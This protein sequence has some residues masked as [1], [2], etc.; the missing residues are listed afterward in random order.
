MNELKITRKEIDGAFAGANITTGSTGPKGGN[1]SYGGCSFLT[2]DFYDLGVPEISVWVDKQ[3]A[4]HAE[5]HIQGAIKARKNA[6]YRTAGENGCLAF[7]MFGDQ[8]PEDLADILEA[9]AKQLRQ[10]CNSAPLP[11]MKN[12]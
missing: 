8:E 10:S 9:A 7:L 11:N 3:G 6:Q 12:S 4:A 2:I 5:R 1:S